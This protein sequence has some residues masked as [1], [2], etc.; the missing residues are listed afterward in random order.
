MI[1]GKY[2]VQEVAK[3]GEEG[4]NLTVLHQGRRLARFGKI[5]NQYAFGTADSTLSNAQRELGRMLVLA[6]AGMHVQVDPSQDLAPIE[7]IV[8]LDV[9]MPDRRVRNALIRN[10][11]HPRGDVH[12]PL[13]HSAVLEIG[14]LR[15]ESE[16]LG[17][18]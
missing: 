18:E 1:C 4:L 14:G 6:F 11:E 16:T 9:R 17:L 5:A 15:V 8:G 12:H 3:C 2:V 13:L 10:S 7:H